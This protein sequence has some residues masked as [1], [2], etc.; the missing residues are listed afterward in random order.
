[1]IN[2][3]GDQIKYQA[4]INKTM[5]IDKITKEKR[6]CFKNNSYIWPRKF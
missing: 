3:H 5:R 6:I 1:M 4:N 2:L